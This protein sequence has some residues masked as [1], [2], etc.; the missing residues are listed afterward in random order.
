MRKLFTALFFSSVCVNCGLAQQHENNYRAAHWGLDEGLSQGETYHMIK[1]VNGFLWIGTRYGLN[2]FDGN[3]FKVYLHQRNNDKSLITNDVRGGLVE[4]S[5]H[6][7]WI[8]SDLGVSRYNIRTEDFTNFFSDTLEKTPDMIIPFWATKNEVL[9]MERESFVE[10]YDIHSSAKRKLADLDVYSGK[11]IGVAWEYAIFDTV[12]NS[13]WCLVEMP[14][15]KSG[16][17]QIMLSTGQKKFFEFAYPV[18]PNR[19]DFAE[20]L[21]YDALRQC[22]WVNSTEGL[23][24]F[25]LS[26][27]QFHHINALYKYERVKD[28]DRFVGIT[29]DKLNRVWFATAPKGIIIYNPV[30]ESISFPFPGDP[31][32]QHDVSD[33]NACIYC[34]RDNITWSGYWLRKGISAFVPYSPV[35]KQSS[36]NSDFVITVVDAGKGKVWAGTN[37][38]INILDTKTGTFQTL[39]QKDLPGLQTNDGVIGAIAIDTIGQKAWLYSCWSYWPKDFFKEDIVTKKCTPILVKN[40]NNEVVP[41]EGSPVFDG[42]EIFFFDKHISVLN[43]ND[44]T[45]HE[46]LSISDPYYLI[47]SVPVKNKFLFLEGNLT[48]E[49]GNMTYENRSGKWVL[50]H[51]PIDSIRWTSIAYINDSYWMAGENKLFHLD[52]SFHIIQTYSPEN[53]LAELPVAGLIN[54]NNGN[55]WFHTDRSIQELNIATDQ[56]KTMSNLDGFEKQNLNL[57][58]YT[59]RDAN[60]NI[61]Y[62][63]EFGLNTITPGNFISHISSVYL[64]SLSI[65]QKPLSLKESITYTDTLWLKYDQTKIEIETGIIDF[66]SQGKSRL[67]YKLEGTGINEN[68]HYA[69]YYYTVR[70]DGLQPGNYKLVMQASNVSNEFNGPAKTL[71]INISP[72]FWNTWWFRFI[73][74]ICAVALVY[75]LIRWRL[76]QKFNYRLEKS[77]KEKQLAELKDKTSQL[78]METLR[79]QMNPH[80]IFNCLSSINRFILKNKTEEAS[81]YLTKFSRLIRMVLNNSKKSFISLEDELETLRLY[82][83]MERLRF[84]NS[85][86]YSFTYNNSVDLGNIFIPPLLLQPFAENAIWHG[87]MHKQEK[88]FLNFD[89]STE[90]KFLLCIITDNGVGRDQAELLKSKS[91]EKQKSLGLKITSERLSL[92]NNNSNEQTFFTIEDLAN[93]NG[94]ALGTRVYLKIYYKEMMEV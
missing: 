40:L 91:V 26:D 86:D 92:L 12:T 47:N 19:Q 1:D 90:E 38:G 46:I 5:L 17:L 36:A 88:G 48:D 20:A 7:I 34:D 60:G 93:E 67:R 31:T 64:K 44:D 33:A 49:K 69:P 45:A 8:G 9:C 2:R 78:E 16:L 52:S 14:E 56:I 84:K 58:P 79:S 22:I 25:T 55:I 81:D 59:N 29:L 74:G 27:K 61:Y 85:F 62:C 77:E 72:A 54:D 75:G 42:K 15:R 43:L 35:I 89:F 63:G 10:A 24:Q 76:H 71:F 28:Y 21:C 94:N 39:Q 30:D 83:E 51:T 37:K 68:W 87:L 80:F 18:K 3:T 11:S 82:L 4:D 66:Y 6:N 13:I 32:L 65:N 23:L 41:L 53:G 57:L 70:Y 50:V 73:A